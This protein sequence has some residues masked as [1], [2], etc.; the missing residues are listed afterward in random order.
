MYL[1]GTPG[2]GHSQ[3]KPSLST[4]SCQVVR[5]YLGWHLGLPAREDP[6]LPV[7]WCS[8]ARAIRPVPKMAMVQRPM[9]MR[10]ADSRGTSSC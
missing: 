9:Y 4:L 3:P 5:R 1:P 7:C 10:D 2:T 8:K 6:V